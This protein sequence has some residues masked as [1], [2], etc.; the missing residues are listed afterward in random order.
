MTSFHV[1][2]RRCYIFLLVPYCL[3]GVV[4]H[5]ADHRQIDDNQVFAN[6]AKVMRPA[7]DGVKAITIDYGFLPSVYTKANA[8]IVLPNIVVSDARD[9]VVNKLYDTLFKA[10]KAT[11]VGQYELAIQTYNQALSLQP[12]NADILYSIGRLYHRAGELKKAKAYYERVLTFNP[13]HK[14]AMDSF[15][16]VF[17]AIYP[18][19]AL[20][21]LQHLESLNSSYVPILTQIALV[22]AKKQ[23]FSNAIEY[24]QK[25]GRL[26]PNDVLYRYNL[27][28]TYDRMGRTADAIKMYKAVIEMSDDGTSIPCPKNLLQQRI[29]V[30]QKGK[31]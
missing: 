6:I 25:I 19:Q 13:K 31:T 17:A 26:A 10:Y 15:L 3:Y 2:L 29:S 30:L 9:I 28:V 12:D 21:E 18:N 22:Y 7:G 8:D 27:A 16:A 14:K 11:T 4:S 5:A 20:K 1:Y 24:F 23:M